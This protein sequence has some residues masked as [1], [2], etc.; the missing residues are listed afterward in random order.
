[1]NDNENTTNLW[2]ILNGKDALKFEVSLE[3]ETIAYLAVGVFVVGLVL[4]AIS[5]AWPQKR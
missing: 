2:G 1:M 3:G 5:K 4:I